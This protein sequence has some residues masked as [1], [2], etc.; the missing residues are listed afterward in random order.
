MKANNH[1]TAAKFARRLLD[2]NPDPKI[3]AQVRIVSVIADC[4]D[5]SSLL[6]LDNVLQLEIETQEM[7]SRF[8]MTSS[9]NSIFVRQVMRL[10]TAAPLLYTAPTPMHPISLNSKG[11]SIPS[12]TL[13]KSVLPRQGYLL[14]DRR[15]WTGHVDYV[16]TTYDNTLRHFIY[17]PE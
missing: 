10:Y 4:S 13:L 17:T 14:L 12:L 2:L 5:T 1:A 9:Q 15:L 11:N 16:C 6:R 8:R 3:V 7:R